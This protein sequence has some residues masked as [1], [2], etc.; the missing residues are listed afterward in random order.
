MIEELDAVV[1]CLY[2]LSA[3]QLTHIFDS[4]HEWPTDRERTVWSA[5]RDRTLT[6][7]GSLT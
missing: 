5:R 4:F 1:A 7:L 6:I 3:Q 2:G